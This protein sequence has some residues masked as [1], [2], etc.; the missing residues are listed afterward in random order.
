[1]DMVN[2]MTEWIKDDIQIKEADL[3][4]ETPETTTEGEVIIADPNGRT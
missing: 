4:I 1:M 2:N 3:E